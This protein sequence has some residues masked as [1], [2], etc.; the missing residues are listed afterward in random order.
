MPPIRI[1][2]VCP[3]AAMPRNDASTSMESMLTLCEPGQGG[4][5]REQ[6]EERDDLEHGEPPLEF[7]PLG[8]HAADL[9][10]SPALREPFAGPLSREPATTATSS[11]TP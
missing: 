6:H 3:A 1:T 4:S 11:T 8:D 2:I 7:L 5:P 10:S 9:S